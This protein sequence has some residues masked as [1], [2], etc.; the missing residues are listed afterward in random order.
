MES[1]F[2]L[3]LLLFKKIKGYFLKLKLGL[4]ENMLTSNLEIS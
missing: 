4:K 3:G 2:L 1:N